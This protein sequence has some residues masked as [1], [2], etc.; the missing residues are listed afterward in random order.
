MI[1]SPFRVPYIHVVYVGR[2][3]FEVL[4]GLGGCPAGYAYYC[5]SLVVI[6]VYTTSILAT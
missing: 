4:E 6:H 3:S 5:P 2:V 1:H